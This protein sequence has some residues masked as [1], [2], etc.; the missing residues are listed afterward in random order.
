MHVLVKISNYEDLL[1]VS[2][3]LA[4]EE[5][6][7]LFKSRLMLANLVILG[8]EGEAVRDPAVIASKD[9]DFVLIDSKAADCVAS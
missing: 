4:P 9:K 2:H 6:L 3:R 7:R 1:I 8:I 5:L